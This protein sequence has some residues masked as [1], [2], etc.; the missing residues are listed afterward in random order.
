MT[1]Q[2]VISVDLVFESQENNLNRTEIYLMQALTT[3]FPGLRNANVALAIRD[4][5]GVVVRTV[6]FGNPS[7]EMKRQMDYQFGPIEPPEAQPA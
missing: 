5:A 3:A 7:E 1:K 2:R 6:T 4:E